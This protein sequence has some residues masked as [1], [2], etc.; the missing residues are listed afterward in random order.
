[1]ILWLWLFGSIAN[2]IDLNDRLRIELDGGERVEGYFLRAG[3][4]LVVMTRPSRGDVIKVSC[5]IVSSVEVNGSTVGADR[6]VLEVEEAW[7][8]RLD[9]IQNAPPVPPAA[10][11]GPLNL[12]IAG[13]GHAAL[14]RWDVG[15]SMMAVDAISMTVIGLELAGKGTQRMDV[16][17]SAAAIS[18]LFK[19]YAFSDGLR[20]VRRQ[21][22]RRKLED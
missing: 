4:G 16:L 20:R 19:S 13:S 7:Q 14:N 3:D 15:G 5:A 1:V 11:I 10:L 21:T 18:A 17:V 9:W 12:L 22:D 8:A 2:A 6:F